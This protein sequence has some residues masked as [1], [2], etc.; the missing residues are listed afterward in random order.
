V[1]DHDL[2]D[3]GLIDGLS[4]LLDGASSFSG[5]NII[6]GGSGSDL[7]EG[8]GDNDVIDGD[9]WLNV[10]ISV[11][12]AADPSVEI[13][14]VNSMRDIQGAVF[15]GTISP[16]Q[17]RVIREVRPASVP[18]P[19]DPPDID[20]AV[21]SDLAA[22]YD[23]TDPDA[24]GDITIVHA[25]GTQA[26]GRDKLKGIERMTF[27][28]GTTEVVDIPT[29]TPATGTV[30]ISDMTPTEG[31]QLSASRDFADADG[32]DEVSVRFSWQAQNAPNVWSSEGLGESFTPNDRHAGKR[33]RL[34]ATFQDGDGVTESITSAA[35]EPVENVDTPPPPPPPAVGPAAPQAPQPPPPPPAGQPSTL[36]GKV[37][38][39]LLRVRGL[40]V[41]TRRQ[42]ITVTVDVPSATKVV[43]IQVVRKPARRSARRSQRRPSRIVGT[44]FRSPIE[45]GRHRYRLT[46]RKLRRLKAGSYELRVRL[47]RSRAD[48]GPTSKR[49]FTVRKARARR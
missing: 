44:A 33:L 2:T 6:L 39:P 9:R 36:V 40:S 49:N 30:G 27:A 18:G 45:G 19:G 7:I 31:Q 48:L 12:S 17:L 14:S 23:I 13:Q 34:V 46:E 32:I 35:T 24:T 20:T 22:N 1:A 41:S 43:R 29:N 25:R 21:F 16:S 26:D 28:D 8:R 10:R 37:L 4:G 5:G 15:A 11:R 38:A 42:P 47:G 3:V